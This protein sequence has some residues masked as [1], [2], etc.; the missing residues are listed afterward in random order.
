MV[1]DPFLE[2]SI[3]N[4]STQISN[5]IYFKRKWYFH[6]GLKTDLVRFDHPLTQRDHNKCLEILFE[7]LKVYI[8]KPSSRIEAFDLKAIKIYNPLFDH[9]SI[10]DLVSYARRVSPDMVIATEDEIDRS[11]WGWSSAEEEATHLVC[12]Y[13]D[14]DFPYMDDDDD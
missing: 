11:G 1:E 6:D 5:S 13:S 10:S 2:S 12:G 9:V 8:T 4:Y 7:Q 14:C 3:V